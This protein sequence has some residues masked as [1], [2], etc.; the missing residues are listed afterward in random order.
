MEKRSGY[1]IPIAK[2]VFS[3]NEAELI[4]Q[5][6]NSGWVSQGPLVEQFEQSVAKYTQ[7]KHAVATTSC[8]T[9]L[10]IAM[11]INNIGP[12]CDM[13]CPSYSFIA[14]A[15][16]VSHAGATPCF[17]DI[18]PATLNMCPQ[19]TKKV[20]AESYTKN[21]NGTLVNKKTGNKLAG[22][23]L[24]HQ[25]GIPADIDTFAAICRENNI[26]LIED[27]ACGIG[28]IYKKTP[29][30]G[31]GFV[32]ALSFHP[33]KVITTGEGG[34]LL[35]SDDK[36]DEASR[37]WRA[38][39]ASIS[40][41]ARHKSGST[42]Y[43]TYDVK[44]Y[45]YRM[46]DIQAAIGLKQMEMLEGLIQRRIEIGKRFNEAFASIENI[47]I[48]LPASYVG[49]WNYQSY[50][51]RLRADNSMNADA[52]SKKRDAVMHELTEMG[53]ATRRGIPPIHK[54]SVYANG[55]TLPNTESVSRRSFFLP[56]F[57]T[58]KDDEVGYI[59]ESVT[60]AVKAKALVG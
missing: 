38:H 11:L 33:R 34:M 9:A 21:A 18:D 13:L 49:R 59:I 12:G 31:S 58:L 8:T 44:G 42:V 16:G 39:G 27:T 37:M 57:P 3:G 40:D 25:I 5:A 19:E 53:I 60:K 36:L 35:M 55:L 50:P 43:E 56:I 10:H 1:N 41:F 7:A 22:M 32:N 20:I 30:G 28:S 51:V 2:P 24:V 4:Q 17:V 47:E 26:V 54:E 15:N 14:S 46:T 52:E 45:N 6:L 48:I 23:V 29:L